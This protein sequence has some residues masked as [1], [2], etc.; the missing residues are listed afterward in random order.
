MEIPQ[1]ST[2]NISDLYDGFQPYP[3]DLQDQAKAAS[4][5][6]DQQE[7]SEVNDQLKLD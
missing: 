3:E 4:D 2:Q 6:L 5:L 1:G 7:N